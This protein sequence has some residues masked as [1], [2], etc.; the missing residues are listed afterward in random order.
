MADPVDLIA[1][2]VLKQVFPDP[3]SIRA[4]DQIQQQAIGTPASLA[5]VQFLV[6]TPDP[7]VPAGLL[8]TANA[9]I[10]FD[11][12]TPGTIKFNVNVA[13]ALGY[14]PAHSGANSDITSLSGLTTA[15]SVLQG[16]TGATTAANARTN[17]NAAISGANADITSLSG[18][19]TAL[20]VAQGG[21]GRTTAPP[22]FSAYRN[23]A[24][25]NLPNAAFTQVQ[26]N[27]TSWN[28]GVCYDPVTNFRFTPTV[29]GKYLLTAAVNVT[30]GA[31]ST[32][33][34]IASVFKNGVEYRRCSTQQYA[35]TIGTIVDF[36]ASCL[37]EANG[38]TD[39]FDIRLFQ[40]TGAAS[41]INPNIELSWFQGAY[42]TP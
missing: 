41:T 33:T 23:G 38:T 26:F 39:F 34:M 10:S 35:V 21:T 25:Q 9:G 20:S 42:Q 22:T 4:F 32:P 17:L 31:A 29:A 5:G 28:T 27:T 3:R 7:L 19:T 30:L 14:T 40:S 18:L 24:T 15:L 2:D 6:Y 1:R 37:V 16:G 8:L 13:G 12:A 11:T 36:A